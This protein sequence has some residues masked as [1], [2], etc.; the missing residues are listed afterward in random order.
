MAFDA[1]LFQ[2]VTVQRK[3][4]ERKARAASE[5]VPVSEEVKARFAMFAMAC[6]KARDANKANRVA[7]RALDGSDTFDKTRARQ[8][9]RNMKASGVLIGIALQIVGSEE[10]SRILGHFANTRP[11]YNPNAG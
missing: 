10:S 8:I 1:K 5:R 7:Y 6:D 3:K 4:I 2:V 11:T 9:V